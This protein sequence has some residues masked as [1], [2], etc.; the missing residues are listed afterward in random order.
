MADSSQAK[1]QVPSYTSV[2]L[3]PQLSS[4]LS[5][6]KVSLFSLPLNFLRAESTLD[7]GLDTYN[8]AHS[9]QQT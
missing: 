9:S 1:L 3:T 5:I 2:N 7:T 8:T 4:F 6:G